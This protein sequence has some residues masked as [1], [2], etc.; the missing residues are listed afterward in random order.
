MNRNPSRTGPIADWVNEWTDATVPDRVR[1]V[2]RIVKANAVITNT[3]FQAWRA[4]RLIWT[5]AEC[6]KAVATS[7]GMSEAFSTGSQAQYPP[8]ERTSYAHQAPSTIPRVKKVQATSVE[9]GYVG[10][11]PPPASRGQGPR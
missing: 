2:P 7:Q 9:G 4:P 11:N 10:A 8:H 5:R 1:K 3:K 6:R